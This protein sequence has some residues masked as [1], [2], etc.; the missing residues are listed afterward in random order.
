[1]SESV[2]VDQLISQI[3]SIAHLRKLEAEKKAVA[4]LITKELEAAEERML[5]LL[6]QANLKNFKSDLGTVTRTY[7]TSVRTPKTPEDR[8]AFFEYLKK[9]GLYDSMISVNSVSL[10]S[11]Y[12]EGLANAEAAGLADF[13]IPGINE[14]TLIPTLSFR[15]A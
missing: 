10:T 15:R 1:M 7:R 4:S 12:K 8:Q 6:E 5:E 14:V 3:E 11:Y 13:S 2:V 9:E